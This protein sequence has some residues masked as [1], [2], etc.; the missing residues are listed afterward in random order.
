M[1]GGAVVAAP[2][3][4]ESS[5]GAGAVVA[6]SAGSD[7]VIDVDGVLRRS[8]MFADL[9][10]AGVVAELVGGVSAVSVGGCCN[11]V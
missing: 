8:G 2:A 5:V 11:V 7:V 6:A 10:M 4:L 3:G 9:V 1:G